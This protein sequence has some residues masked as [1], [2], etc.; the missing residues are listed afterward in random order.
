[1]TNKEY[2]V[3]TDKLFEEWK[4]KEGRVGFSND[5][6]VDYDKYVHS[7]Y[8]ILFLLKETNNKERKSIDLTKF[9]KEGANRTHTW[10]NIARW[11]KVMLQDSEPIWDNYKNIKVEKKDLISRV[12][13]MNIK[14]TSGGHTANNKEIIQI[15]EE[16][17]KLIKSQIEL[18]NPDIIISC[19]SSVSN[20]INN[21]IADRIGGFYTRN[22]ISCTKVLNKVNLNYLHP[23]CRVWDNILLF[24]FISAFSE[25][26]SQILKK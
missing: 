13:V 22:G 18:I 21:N 25:I 14:K 11:I 7:R 12:A 4:S 5:G 1:M 3:K 17:S 26:E 2:R 15:A 20:F 6:I 10:D 8:K 24:G 16:D 23:N 19:G 9:L